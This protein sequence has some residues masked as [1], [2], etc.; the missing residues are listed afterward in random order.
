MRPS[1]LV[2]LTVLVSLGGLLLT[3]CSD[4][5][6]YSEA[7]LTGVIEDVMDAA[8]VEVDRNYIA[9][10]AR[11]SAPGC[12]EVPEDDRWFAVQT[13]QILSD[14]Q[15]QERVYDGV[16]AYLEGNDFDVERYVSVPPEA[17][18]L[19]LRGVRDDLVVQVAVSG[20]GNSHIRVAAGPCAEPVNGYSDDRYRRAD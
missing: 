12:R 11:R 18:V 1:R 7:R 13:G 2:V 5:D 8:D 3:G 17:D 20:D 19:A 4:D 15:S 14:R 10:Y 9:G 6:Q 16:L